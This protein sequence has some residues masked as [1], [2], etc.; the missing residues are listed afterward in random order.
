MG[1]GNN[2]QSKEKKKPK[3][4]AAPKAGPVKASDTSAQEAVTVDRVYRRMLTQGWS[5]RQLVGLIPRSRGC[6]SHPLR[7]HN[8][9]SATILHPT[10]S[11]RRCRSA[12]PE[13]AQMRGIH[14]GPRSPAR[15]P[16]L[17]ARTRDGLGTRGYRLEVVSGRFRT[18]PKDN[19]DNT[20]GVGPSHVVDCTDANLVIHD[21][22]TGA[23]LQR[24]TQTS[25]GKTRSPVSRCRY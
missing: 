16:L 8:P 23:V 7:Q 13:T 6:E 5:S 22:K 17:L 4:A 9:L 21:K 3:K 2:S 11:A 12:E 15:V 14:E 19:P 20:G 24:M 10:S 25:S 1:K 18:G